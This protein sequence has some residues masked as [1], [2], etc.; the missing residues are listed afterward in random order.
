MAHADS[1]VFGEASDPCPT[2]LHLLQ[3][4]V[5]ACEDILAGLAA[6]GQ[7]VPRVRQLSRPLA[8]IMTGMPWAR[9]WRHELEMLL[10]SGQAGSIGEVVEAMVKLMPAGAL[11]GPIGLPT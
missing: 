8:D 3:R 6:L 1:V 2:R 7:Q 10:A 5:A 4:Y 11:E 9:R